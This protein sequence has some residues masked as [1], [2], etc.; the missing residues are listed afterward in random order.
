MNFPLTPLDIAIWLA[1]TAIILLVTSELLYV[2]PE[3]SSKIF[4][5]KTRMRFAGIGV[6]L[7]FLVLVVWLFK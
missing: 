6:G 4:I 7:A 2:L 1:I 3:F 5:D